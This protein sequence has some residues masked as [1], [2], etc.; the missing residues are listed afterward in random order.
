MIHFLIRFL[1]LSFGLSVSAA[2]GESPAYIP[3]EAEVTASSG[4]VKLTLRVY[5]KSFPAAEK[6][7]YQIE[8]KNVGK[9]P[10]KFDSRFF[11][12][13][14]DPVDSRFGVYLKVLDLKGRPAGTGT[15][16]GEGCAPDR[17]PLIESIK[18]QYT[19]EDS[20]HLKAKQAE[21]RRAGLS[22]HVVDALM[23]KEKNYLV[24]NYL[25]P[26][27]PA[28]QIKEYELQPG[29]SVTTPPWVCTRYASK[30]APASKPIGQYAQYWE[31]PRLEWGPDFIVK[32]VYGAHSSDEVLKILQKAGVQPHPEDVYVE[33]PS[34]RIRLK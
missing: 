25:P 11:P 19:K 20:D 26:A 31:M 14:S 1:L 6:L 8:I 29:Q 34:V 32:A 27:P 24:E 16:P 3:P 23:L 12:H 10:I 22:E 5:K 7:R 9:R 30:R 4:P 18:I 13:P 33:T 2:E 28:P 15:L 21:F 17:G